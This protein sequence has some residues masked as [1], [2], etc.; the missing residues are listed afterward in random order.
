MPSS[1][2]VS[3]SRRMRLSLAPLCSSWL[4]VFIS[5]SD[6]VY[7]SRGMICLLP[8][9]PL[10]RSWLEE[11]MSILE[12]LSSSRGT[13]CSA[14]APSKRAPKSLSSGMVCDCADKSPPA[15]ASGLASKR[16]AMVPSIFLVRDS[17]TFRSSVLSAE[18]VSIS[19]GMMCLSP[20]T[21]LRS[22]WLAVL[23]SNSEA[24]SSSRGPSSS[25]PAPSKR[26]PKLISNGIVCDCVDKSPF[27]ALP[28]SA[29][30]ILFV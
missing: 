22:S 25:L 6:V 7:I 9:S 29:F 24:V 12:I 17:S 27:V 3:S 13:S 18:I 16:D 20:T 10:R 21:L 2:I 23:M 14:P 11:S 15:S 5:S 19:R 28:G 26:D 8:A 1:E 4:A 30:S